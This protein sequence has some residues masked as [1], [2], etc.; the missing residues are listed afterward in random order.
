MHKARNLL[1]LLVMASVQLSVLVIASVGVGGAAPKI[2]RSWTPVYSHDFADPDVLLYQGTYYGYATQNFAASDQTVNIQTAT[3]ADGVT[4]T[5]QGID[6]LPALPSW[7][8]PDAAYPDKNTWSPS[9]AYDPSDDRFV[10]YFAATDTSD[11]PSQGEQ[12]IGMAV[13]SSPEGPF[14]DSSSTPFLCQANLGGSIDP[15]IFTDNDGESFLIWKNDGNKIDGSGVPTAPVGI[16][17]QPLASYLT[18]LTG[19]PSE[20]LTSDQAW[21]KT[22]VEGVVEGPDMVEVGGTDYLFYS[23]ND[24]TT[25]SYAIGYASCPN[26]PSAPC[27]DG[28]S[29]PILTSA[30]GMS[31]PGGP[32]VYASRSGQLEMAFAAWTSTEV[33]GYPSGGYRPMFLADLTFGGGVPVLSTVGTLTTAAT[34]NAPSSPGYWEVASD[35][36]VFSFGSAQFYGST[37][38]LRLNE[39]VVGMA[40]T[41]DG[42]GY[43]LVASDG[44]VFS[45]GDAQ[46]YGSTGSVQLNKPIVGM[47]ATADGGGYWLVAS[48][49]GI[50]AFGDAQFYGSTGGSK[51]GGAVVGM[52]PSAGGEG[53]WLVE[54]NGDV[55]AFGN[56]KYYGEPT[57]AVGSSRIVD[58]ASTVNSGGYWLASANGHIASYGDAESEGSAFGTSLDG[59]IV[60]ISATT[61]RNGYWLVG[62]DGGIFCYG[63]ATFEGSMGGQRLNSP[64]VGLSVV[65]S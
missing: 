12:C 27:T 44:G 39:P 53:Y 29:N 36:G 4:W 16:W 6:A 49:G 48:D 37:G 45:F 54:S 64:V 58:M 22:S 3:S 63:D 17:S 8:T 28:S 33:V 55:F 51:L 23:G 19:S 18:S 2:E 5:S 57:L 14:V 1:T 15:D 59:A 21:Q 65:G 13:S 20:I 41:P 10:M 46:F 56:T 24:E 47:A 25:A 43:W 30:I 62:S 7:A 31:G 9:V 35:G 32:S 61:D 40:S 26:G 11:D 60:G 52:T 38:S 42:H 34:T 50:F